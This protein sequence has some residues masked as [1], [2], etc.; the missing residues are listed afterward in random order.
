MGHDLMMVARQKAMTIRTDKEYSALASSF[1]H[2]ARGNLYNTV[3]SGGRLDDRTAVELSLIRMARQTKTKGE[4]PVPVIILEQGNRVMEQKFCREGC[5]ARLSNGN[6]CIEPLAGLSDREIAGR[7][8][9][10]AK[11]LDS[12][13]SSGLRGLLRIGCELLRK[14]NKTPG[15]M[16]LSQLPWNRLGAYIDRMVENDELEQEEAMVILGELGQLSGDTGQADD[17]LDQLSREYSTMRA[18]NVPVVSLEQIIAGDGVACLRLVSGMRAMRELI[19]LSLQKATLQAKQF[20]LVADSVAIPTGESYLRELLCAHSSEYALVMS[21]EDMPAR[22]S[23][24]FAGLISGD[25]NIVLFAHQSGNST[26]AWANFIGKSYQIKE[27]SS[28]SESRAQ[29]QLLDRQIS[30]SRSREEELRYRIACE[31]IQ[32]L[33]VGQAI[34]QS[35]EPGAGLWFVDFPRLFTLQQNKALQLRGR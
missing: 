19:A 25:T 28:Y 24:S 13:C 4:R 30:K 2:W 29:T 35:G 18:E 6:A 5:N 14:Q 34:V 32:S 20:L 21:Y 12:N 9:T 11:T 33:P 3:I 17:L 16:T 8:Y 7:L 23:D 26:E 15:I 31:Q 22:L 10:V 1:I 27:S